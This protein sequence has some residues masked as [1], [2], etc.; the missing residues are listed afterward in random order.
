MSDVVDQP[1]TFSE[2]IWGIDWRAELPWSHG[3]IV[4]E[5]ATFEEGLAFVEAHYPAIF[6]PLIG[7]ARFVRDAMTPAKRRFGAEMDVVAFRDG[8]AT[9]GLWMAHPTDWSTYYLRSGGLL[10]AYRDRRIIGEFMQHVSGVLRRAG[11]DR[12]DAECSPSNLASMRLMTR[13]GWVVTSTTNSE[14]WG[15]V[16][17]CSKFLRE[18]AEAVFLRQ[19]CALSNGRSE[20]ILP[21]GP[22]P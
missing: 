18:E 2:R 16:V 12:F 15:A 10:E 21:E 1:K 14:R 5:V 9:I 4:A 20:R 8:A 11:V 22:Q 17:R 6:G 3:G 13:L 7:E 19:F